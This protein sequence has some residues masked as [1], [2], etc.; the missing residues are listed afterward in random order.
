MRTVLADEDE[1]RN[2]DSNG[3]EKSF[4]SFRKLGS[5][6]VTRVHGNERSTGRVE[7]DLIRLNDDAS[8]L[9]FDSIAY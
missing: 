1:I 7:T 8:G 3:A 2:H 5:A 4:E 9:G 6:E